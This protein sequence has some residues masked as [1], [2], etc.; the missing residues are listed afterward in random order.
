V[1][2]AVAPERASSRPGDA[3][4]AWSDHPDDS[5]YGKF[6][7]HPGLDGIRGLAMAVIFVFHAGSDLFPGATLSLSVFFTLSGYLITRLLLDEGIRNAALDLPRF[8]ARRLRRLLPAALAGIGLVLVLSVLNALQVDPT[9]LQLDVFGAL[10]YSANW[11]FLFAGSSYGDLFEQPSPLLHYWSLAVEEQ[12]YLLLPLVVWFVLR[13]SSRARDFR[14]RLRSVLL[15]GIALSLG[16][17]VV[18]AAAGNFD[19][20]YYSLPSRAGE[21]LVGG[22][23]A[24]FAA[25]A[26]AG[27]RPAKPWM[28]AVGFA[29]LLAIGVLCTIPTPTDGWIGWGG[30]TIFAVLSA[31]MI[32][33]GTPAGPFASV[34][35]VWPLRMLGIISYGL[36]L[37]HWPVILWLTPE[38]TGLDG[39]LLVLF[40]AAVTIALAIVSYKLL[41][42][43]IRTG[44]LLRGTGARVAA[45][46]GIAAMALTG[47]LITN[48]L[49]TPT[50]LD[51][52]DAAEAVNV[53]RSGTPSASESPPGTDVPITPVPPP[54]G[55]PSVAF[56]GDSTGLMTAK[57]FKAWAAESPDVRLAG[58]AAW[59]GCGMVREG[60]ARFNG[61]EFDPGACGDL[62]T[63]WAAA[64]DE[65]Q[66]QIA[67]IQAGPIDVDDHLL[68][69]DSKWR[70][71]GDPVFDRRLKESMLEAVDVF[72]ERGVVPIWLTSPRIEPSR[73]TQPPNEDPAGDPARMRRF[74]E[75]LAEIASERPAL[76]VVDLAG[77]V[78]RW[79]GGE[80]DPELRPDGVHFDEHAA[81]E[82]VSPWLSNAILREWRAA[83]GG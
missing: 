52:A 80:L 6:G 70:A 57:G 35:A 33:A 79:P 22:V 39:T 60:T 62:T 68:P 59:Y 16:T 15:V 82:H 44:K 51:F 72:L 63:Q 65:A 61:R 18:A 71:P 25:V 11:R 83:S 2:T 20:V 32:S 7:Y 43:P 66:P 78:K 17:S 36:Y 27:E 64:I 23:F 73:S 26:R 24:T 19:F 77:W 48:T 54:S 42:R 30:M 75:L 55:A 56:F 9:G 12:F 4:R 49:S 29:S 10:G 1:S 46:F 74:N 13:R 50:H 41:E 37:Y 21:L 40:Q 8:W 3:A 34:L 38:R 14:L 5:A 47:F 53:G 81:A 28:T 67:V 31:T 58:G 76:R 45:P 69:G